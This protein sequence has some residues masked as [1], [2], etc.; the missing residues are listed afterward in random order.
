MT[1]FYVTLQF[2]HS[3]LFFSPCTRLKDFTSLCY[4]HPFSCLIDNVQICC[5]QMAESKSTAVHCHS[6]QFTS[7]LSVF[8]FQCCCVLECG[9]HWKTGGCPLGPWGPRWRGQCCITVVCLASS[10]WAET[11]HSA[12]RW[13]NGTHPNQ[14]VTV[15]HS[16]PCTPLHDSKTKLH[17]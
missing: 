11:Q 2:P 7:P 14:C 4:L 9:H 3:V 8:L 1:C 17:S 15:S 10:S 16:T 13:A 5:L 12:I 6:S